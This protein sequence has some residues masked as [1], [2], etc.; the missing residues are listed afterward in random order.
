MH[1]SVI[2]SSPA[3]VV[4]FHLFLVHLH[5]LV[6]PFVGHLLLALM[7]SSVMCS[8]PS[9]H[10]SII[11]SSSSIHSSV[12]MIFDLWHFKIGPDRKSTYGLI[13]II[14]WFSYN[15]RRFVIET[16]NSNVNSG[17]AEIFSEVRTTHQVPPP[18]PPRKDKVTVSLRIFT[19]Y[20]MTALSNLRNLFRLF[21]I[22]N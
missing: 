21:W 12:I 11:S 8:S 15:V 1:S 18:P 4:H 10:A 3:F 6:N 22:H 5:P 16:G 13:T 20:E 19:V 2:C 9:M 17:V 7:H 14:H